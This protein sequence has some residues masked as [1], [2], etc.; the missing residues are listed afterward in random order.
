MLQKLLA[1]LQNALQKWTGHMLINN[2]RF[3]MCDIIVAHCVM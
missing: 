2:L 3:W 1:H